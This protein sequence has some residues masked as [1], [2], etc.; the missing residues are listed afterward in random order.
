[1]RL[2]EVHERNSHREV[3]RQHLLLLGRIE[4]HL[5]GLGPGS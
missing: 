3:E 2:E 5:Q 1:M 4:N